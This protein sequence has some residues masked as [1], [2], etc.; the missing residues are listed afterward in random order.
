MTYLQLLLQN[1]QGLL[2]NYSQNLK[3]SMNVISP[4]RATE[5]ICIAH[6]ATCLYANA[7]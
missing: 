5:A 1:L 2:Q 6:Y 7:M 3:S 4:K